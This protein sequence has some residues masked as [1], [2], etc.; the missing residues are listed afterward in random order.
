MVQKMVVIPVNSQSIAKSHQLILLTKEKAKLGIVVNLAMLLQ[1]VQH[2]TQI[3]PSQ[4][5][6][7]CAPNVKTTISAV[8]SSAIDVIRSRPSKIT[9]ESQNTSLRKQVQPPPSKQKSHN[10]I[11][12]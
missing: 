10:V 9:M 5:E 7:G 8:E 6:V 3:F 2:K 11:Q 4:M 1:I 12:S